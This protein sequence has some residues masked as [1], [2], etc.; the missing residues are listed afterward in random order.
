MALEV[1]KEV[2]RQLEHE[3]RQLQ[4]APQQ[5]AILKLQRAFE[6]PS[7][8]SPEAATTMSDAEFEELARGVVRDYREVLERLA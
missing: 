4:L 3:A 6:M 8:A 2:I 7:S 5:L 1:P